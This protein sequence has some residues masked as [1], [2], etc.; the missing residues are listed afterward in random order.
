MYIRKREWEIGENSYRGALLLTKYW[1]D[2]H[3]KDEAGSRMAH[4]KQKRKSHRFYVI[5]ETQ[6][7]I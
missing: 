7:E 4:I 5:K 2:Y 6:K 3:M 1:W